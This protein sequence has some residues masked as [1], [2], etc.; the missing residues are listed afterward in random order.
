LS[1]NGFVV[2]DNKQLRLHNQ[3]PLG[4][5]E[6]VDLIPFEKAWPPIKKRALKEG[7]RL[8]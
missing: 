7:L 2:F 4:I 8:A 5:M 1:L 6:Y 3:K